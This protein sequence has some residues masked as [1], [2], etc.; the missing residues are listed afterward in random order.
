M[1]KEKKIN[2]F[3]SEYVNRYGRANR[4]MLDSSLDVGGHAK[5]WAKYQYY[6]NK[7]IKRRDKRSVIFMD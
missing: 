2:H 4:R 5:N 7:W 1:N 3:G 6:L